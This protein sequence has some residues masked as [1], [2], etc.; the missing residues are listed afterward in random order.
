MPDIDDLLNDP[1]F[2]HD[3]AADVQPPAFGLLRAA[4]V[5]RS[6]RRHALAGGASV[7]AVLAVLG[8]VWLGAGGDD[9]AGAPA[10]T[11]ERGAKP[12]GVDRAEGVGHAGPGASARRREAI[13]AGARVV[14]G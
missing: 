8:G 6:R 11:P 4:G 2:G 13:G 12:D 5:G 9:D 3:V 7:L 14:R 1:E 10:G